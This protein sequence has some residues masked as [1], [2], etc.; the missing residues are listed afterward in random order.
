MDQGR[1]CQS[2]EVASKIWVECSQVLEG[3]L[4]KLGLSQVARAR[5][6]PPQAPRTA[7]FALAS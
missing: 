7:P 5:I 3:D 2:R 6:M 1:G 4:T